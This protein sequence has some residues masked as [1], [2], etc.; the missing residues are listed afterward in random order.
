M[1]NDTFYPSTDEVIDM[2]VAPYVKTFRGRYG[3][4]DRY[5]RGFGKVLEP[6]IGKGNI[7]D[8]LVKSYGIEAKNIFCCEIEDE[9]AMIATSKGY[10]LIERDFLELSDPCHFDVVIMNPPFS[11]AA[12]HILK[13]WDVLGRTGGLVVSQINADNLRRPHTFAQEQLCEL[14]KKHG[15]VEFV[16]RPYLNAERPTDVEVAIVRLGKP[17]QKETVDFGGA[18]DY[19]QDSGADT[20]SFEDYTPVSADAISRIVAQYNACR[21]AITEREVLGRKFSFYGKGIK[22]VGPIVPEIDVSVLIDS[23]KN[24]FWR[25]VFDKTKIADVTTSKVRAEFDKFVANTCNMAFTES[26]IIHIL[27]LLVRNSQ[28]TMQECVMQ[29]FD[30]MVSYDKDNKIHN[31]GW[32]TNDGHRVN[33]KV[34]L[35]IRAKDWYSDNWDTWW[36]DNEKSIAD[37]IDKALCFVAGKQFTQIRSIHDTCIKAC[38]GTSSSNNPGLM[39]SEFF[40]I[41]IYKKGTIH[42]TF[43]DEDLWE[44]FNIMAAQNRSWIGADAMEKYQKRKE[45][46]TKK[47]KPAA[48]SPRLW[49]E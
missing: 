44:R 38:G 3:G 25:H 19:E 6:S 45:A 27:R 35:P 24:K 14:I 8:R 48:T 1:F 34:I 15:S 28:G 39:S 20:A 18:F 5:L 7:A 46:K 9:L 16:G 22:D 2:M 47:S 33:R 31:E 21:S 13:A 10:R 37:D 17:K 23:L 36:R 30:K 43:R 29:T 4:K 32:L 12:E 40:D 11:N 41:R 49:E 26:N 42:I